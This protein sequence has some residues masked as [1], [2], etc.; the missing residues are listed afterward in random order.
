MDKLIHFE[1]P[2]A[3]PDYYYNAPIDEI[4]DLRFK[5]AKHNKTELALALNKH[6]NAKI[7]DLVECNDDDQLANETDIYY[8]TYRFINALEYTRRIIPEELSRSPRPKEELEKWI[9]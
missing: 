1:E 6:F 8:L 3:L 9:A 4:F 7:C 5:L 2:V